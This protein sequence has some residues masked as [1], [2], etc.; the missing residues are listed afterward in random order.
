MLIK[1]KVANN[2]FAVFNKSNDKNQTNNK[3]VNF[4]FVSELPI[5]SVEFISMFI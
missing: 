3:L 1:D 5:L 4:S 2:I